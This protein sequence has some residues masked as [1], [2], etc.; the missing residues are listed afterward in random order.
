M[1]YEYHCEKCNYNFEIAKHHS[2]HRDPE[3]CDQCGEQAE[4]LFGHAELN[5]DKMEAE[6]YTAF[7]TVVKNRSHRKELMKRHDVIEMGNENP[8]KIEKYFKK[9]REEKR[10]RNWSEV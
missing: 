10:N 9:Q 5:V 8:N 1:L 6:Y 7:K 4:R 2:K 3:K